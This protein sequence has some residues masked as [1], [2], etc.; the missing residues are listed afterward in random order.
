MK[1]LLN[2]STKEC[3]LTIVAKGNFITEKWLA[4][5]ELAQ[6]LFGFIVG[7]L[8]KHGFSLSDIDGIGIFQGPGSFT[9]LR[10]GVTVANTIADSRG[11]A[12][13]G[14]TDDNWM[15]DAINRLESGENDKIVIPFYGN[16]PNITKPKK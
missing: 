14:A 5:R 7:Q 3:E 9:G 13:V 2:T 12:I 16:E 8:T 4:D 15:K 11:I 1:L 6:G 10:I